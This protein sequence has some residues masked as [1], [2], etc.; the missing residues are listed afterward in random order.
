[1]FSGFRTRIPHYIWTSKPCS[2]CQC[3]CS[4]C[5]SQW[6]TC[7][8]L[9][10][11]TVV[12]E[13]FDPEGQNPEL[14]LVMGPHW[15]F[16]LVFTGGLV[17]LFPGACMVIFFATVPLWATWCLA[18]LTLVVLLQLAWLGCGDPGI[19]RRITEKPSSGPAALQKWMWNDQGAWCAFRTLA[20][21]AVPHPARAREQQAPGGGPT[22]RTARR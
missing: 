15:P 6:R 13:R 4:C 12:L 7:N 8:R 9:G 17:V 5:G 2:C 10:N 14:C 21:R 16:A 20:S 3:A 19:A 22:T 11:F 1:M 18:V